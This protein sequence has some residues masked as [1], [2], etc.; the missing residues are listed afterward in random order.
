MFAWAFIPTNQKKLDVLN[1]GSF[2]EDF[3]NDYDTARMVAD[4]EQ[5]NSWTPEE[6]LQWKEAGFT[7][8]PEENNDSSRGVYGRI[9]A[10]PRWPKIRTVRIASL[11]GAM[12]VKD[13]KK[14]NAAKRQQKSR[15]KR[16]ESNPKSEAK[17]GDVVPDEEI[18]AWMNETYKPSTE[19]CVP[20]TALKKRMTSVFANRKL[21]KDLWKCLKRVCPWI[22]DGQHGP[23]KDRVFRCVAK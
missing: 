18:Q 4:C 13:C 17:G 16:A 15:A 7:A 12:D 22:L 21:P 10:S 19:G 6:L 20:R 1:H 2:K 8:V 14:L 23:K 11:A 3:Y 5:L 9:W